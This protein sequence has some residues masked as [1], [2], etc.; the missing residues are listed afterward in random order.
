MCEASSGAAQ[1]G[2][3]RRSKCCRAWSDLCDALLRDVGGPVTIFVPRRD[4]LGG[5]RFQGSL[6]ARRR[7][8]RAAEDGGGETLLAREEWAKPRGRKSHSRRCG[9]AIEAQPC[10]GQIKP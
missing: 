7:C 8:S 3:D 4:G 1:L 6:A 9:Q 5:E 2:A 10:F